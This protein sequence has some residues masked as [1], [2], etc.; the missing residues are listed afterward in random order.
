ML[1]IGPSDRCVTDRQRSVMCQVHG[2]QLR[3][4]SLE[5]R[6][7]L[8]EFTMPVDTD[9][10][11]PVVF[12]G[13]KLTFFDTSCSV[14]ECDVVTGET[15]VLPTL[16]NESFYGGAVLTPE[17]LYASRGRNLAIYTLKNRVNG[18]QAGTNNGT[19]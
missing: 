3:V 18:L 19:V 4:Y 15:K 13:D 1:D 2:Q 5:H 9:L 11:G 17:R 12:S 10:H 8:R 6:A 16:I 14:F 7:M